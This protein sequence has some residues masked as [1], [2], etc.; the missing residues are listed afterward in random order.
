MQQQPSCK[1]NPKTPTQD[2]I[3][4]KSIVFTFPQDW[5]L[6]C[7]WEQVEKSRMFEGKLSFLKSQIGISTFLMSRILLHL[8][9][10]QDEWQ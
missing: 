8:K 2:P 6:A 7:C 1:K 9:C 4:Y 10:Q 5:G 3:T